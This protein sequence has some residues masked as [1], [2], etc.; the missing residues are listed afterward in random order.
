MVDQALI[1]A[2]RRA[3]E[4][5]D[6]SQQTATAADAQADAAEQARNQAIADG[7]SQ[8]EVTRLTDAAAA[9]RESANAAQQQANDNQADALRAAVAVAQ[10]QVGE[11]A[12]SA[13]HKVNGIYLDTLLNFDSDTGQHW[14]ALVLQNMQIKC[15]GPES[16]KVYG[17]TL[18]GILGAKT[19][20]CIMGKYVAIA[21]IEH[22]F[23][24]GTAR[25]TITGFKDDNVGGAKWDQLVG[26]KRE[27][28]IGHKAKAGP[29]ETMK[30]PERVGTIGRIMTKGLTALHISDETQVKA[31]KLS[32][33]IDSRRATIKTL[34]TQIKRRTSEI[35]M[36]TYRANKFTIRGG[37]VTYQYK[38]ALYHGT[39]YAEL[40][41]GAGELRASDTLKLKNGSANIELWGN[42]MAFVG[43]DQ[44]RMR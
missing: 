18:D 13:E 6:S 17:F 41:G 44:I 29:S 7:A 37:R 15:V 26:V 2:A 16:K 27:T 35:S 28:H 19:E 5:A 22:K 9:A 11:A 39:S 24:G 12:H 43:G 31:V 21:P 4:K 33:D 38:D 40:K 42:G 36:W 23:V 34:E 1:E 25:A 30:Y 32:E 3:Q 20:I 14:K 8:A 10:A